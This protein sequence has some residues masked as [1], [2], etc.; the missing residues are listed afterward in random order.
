MTG[1]SEGN[2]RSI[3]Y[4]SERNLGWIIERNMTR[5]AERNL[6]WVVKIRNKIKTLFFRFISFL[7]GPIF[8]GA[9]CK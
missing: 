7:S 1:I 8:S 2:L 6:G 3:T 9:N 4:I 5:I